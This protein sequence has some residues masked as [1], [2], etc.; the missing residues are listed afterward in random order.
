M[1]NS[2]VCILVCLISFLFS[3]CESN[4]VYNQ[5]QAIDNV[6]WEKDKEYYFTFQIE[7]VSIPYDIT[8]ETR[9][10]NLYPYQNLWVFL[11]EEQPIGSLK[12][13]TIE[14]LLANEYGKWV[15]RG[16]S[17]Y[18]SGFPVRTNYM[19][20]NK[21]QYTLSFRQ[22]MRNDALKGI[23]EIGLRIEKAQP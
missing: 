9:N 6:S 7:D 21:G 23:Q 12:R 19:F 16:I 4:I 17:L 18:Q 11:S 22:G 20:P 10:N 2:I 5:Y 8:F 13:D 1:R 3:S 15:G 14:C